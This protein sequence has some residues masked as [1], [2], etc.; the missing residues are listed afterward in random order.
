LEELQGPRFAFTPPAAEDIVENQ[1]FSGEQH[2]SCSCVPTKAMGTC[3][4]TI[5]VSLPNIQL[6]GIC[7]SVPERSFVIETILYGENTSAACPYAQI[8]AYRGF[9]ALGYSFRNNRSFE[10]LVPIA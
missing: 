10:K 9:S 4:V 6:P 2:S 1:W 8:H 5:R 7:S 3:A